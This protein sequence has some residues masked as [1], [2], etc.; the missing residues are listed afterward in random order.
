VRRDRVMESRAP[1][2][3]P[4][5][6]TATTDHVRA[7]GRNDGIAAPDRILMAVAALG[8]VGWVVSSQPLVATVCVVSPTSPAPC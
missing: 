7:G 4:A 1:V 5:P 3:T 2:C 8:I 6:A